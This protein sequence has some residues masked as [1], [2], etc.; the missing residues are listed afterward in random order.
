MQASS[1]PISTLLFARLNQWIANMGR[2]KGSWVLFL[3]ERRIGQTEAEGVR[4]VLLP[5]ANQTRPV[6]I[7]DTSGICGLAVFL[8]KFILLIPKPLLGQKLSPKDTQSWSKLSIVIFLIQCHDLIF[9]FP[10]IWHI[11][12]FKSL[13]DLVRH[14]DMIKRYIWVYGLERVIPFVISQA[15]NQWE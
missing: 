5:Y 12:Y 3:G 10:N 13:R 8:P 2:R 9:S 7:P 11:Y 14:W 15:S 1:N 4:S 6:E